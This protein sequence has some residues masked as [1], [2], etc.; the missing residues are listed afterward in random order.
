VLDDDAFLPAGRY[1][2]VYQLSSGDERARLRLPSPTS[3]AFAVGGAL[4]FGD[5]A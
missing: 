3:R 5:D 2:S 4:F 1:V